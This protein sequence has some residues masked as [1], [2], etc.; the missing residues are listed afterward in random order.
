MRIY[1]C[2]KCT[3]EL[4]VGQIAYDNGSGNF[5]CESCFDRIQEQEKEDAEHV[6]EAA[7][8]ADPNDGCYSHR[9]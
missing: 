9:W 4:E 1:Y 8:C 5:I 7:D 2:S 6:I 3:K